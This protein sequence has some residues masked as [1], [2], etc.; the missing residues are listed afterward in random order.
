MRT[1]RGEKGAMKK[2]LVSVLRLIML[3]GVLV[4]LPVIGNRSQAQTNSQ[5]GNFNTTEFDCPSGACC[6][7]PSGTF[8]DQYASADPGPGLQSVN[9]LAPWSC[10]SVT[11]NSTC[12][13]ACSGTYQQVYLDTACCVP[14]GKACVTGFD[15]CSGICNSDTN[16]CATSGGGCEVTGSTAN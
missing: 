15:C 14:S 12:G 11:K 2:V 16:L 9:T 6:T 5:C 8:K 10:G 1:W 3:V 7:S 4:T 13:V